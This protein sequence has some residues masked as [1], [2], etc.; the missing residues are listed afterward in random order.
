MFEI[1]QDSIAAAY[2]SILEPN[3][4]FVTKAYQKNTNRDLIYSISKRLTVEDITDINYDVSFSYVLKAKG[5]YLLQLSMVGKFF[6][7][8]EFGL[9]REVIRCVDRP[10]NNDEEYVIDKL[11]RADFTQ[12]DEETSKLSTGLN[13]LE[14][15]SVL[16]VYQA[17]FTNDLS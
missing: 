12:I 5:E 2:G 4:S 7:L 11:L 17:L 10:I 9:N 1:I 6:I 3:Y 16:N 8:F 14:S 15:N 13:D